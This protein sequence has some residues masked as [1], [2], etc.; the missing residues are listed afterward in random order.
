MFVSFKLELRLVFGLVV[1]FA[2]LLDCVRDMSGASVCW[3]QTNAMMVDV[4]G[5]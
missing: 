5:R 4:G 2:T 3:V 1:R